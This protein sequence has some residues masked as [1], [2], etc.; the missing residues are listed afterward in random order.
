MNITS[1]KHKPW[2]INQLPWKSLNHGTKNRSI[3]MGMRVPL[4]QQTWGSP[5]CQTLPR[6]VYLETQP[7]PC[8]A[9]CPSK[10]LWMC[11][12]KKHLQESERL[13]CKD[14]GRL[15]DLFTQGSFV[16]GLFTHPPWEIRESI[17]WRALFLLPCGRVHHQVIA[18]SVERQAQIHWGVICFSG[19]STVT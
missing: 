3:L 7:G 11:L 18:S 8:Q 17:E 12:E 19:H 13:A 15:R 2:S 5:V 10:E 9:W 14:K 6:P 16:S 4:F 1:S